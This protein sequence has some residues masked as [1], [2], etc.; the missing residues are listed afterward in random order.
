MFLF[1]LKSVPVQ[2]IPALLITFY[3]EQEKSQKKTVLD[4]VKDNSL[5]MMFEVIDLHQ[6]YQFSGFDKDNC[7]TFCKINSTTQEYLD[8]NLEIKWLF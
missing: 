7:P 6:T 2:I 1:S 5:G 3:R 8:M 4:I